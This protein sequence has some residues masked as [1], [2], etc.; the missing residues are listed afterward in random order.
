MSSDAPRD[1]FE[2]FQT[3]YK[4]TRNTQ[5][6]G[7]KWATEKKDG[8][9]VYT[10]RGNTSPD[11]LTDSSVPVSSDLLDGHNCDAYDDEVDPITPTD[12]RYASPDA[13]TYNPITPPQS[14]K[15]VSVLL[16]P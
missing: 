12:N 5:D 3:V 9:W 1:L 13:Q 8:L 14:S 6:I 15:D 7:Y 4:Y 2:N 11:I 10:N 16:E